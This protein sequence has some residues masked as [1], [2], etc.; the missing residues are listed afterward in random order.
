MTHRFDPTQRPNGRHFRW[1]WALALGCLISSGCQPAMTTSPSARA[2]ATADSG[3]AGTVADWPLTFKHHQFGVVCFD[4]QACE[5]D[6][7]GFSFGSPE[8]SQ[9]KANL[10]ADDYARATTA[11]YGPVARTAAPARVS[12]R[13][14]DGTALQAE[15]DIAELFKDGLVRHR[16]PRA[17]IPDGVS[18]GA[19]HV[20]LEIDDRTIS[21]LTRT[22]IPTREPQIPGNRF[23]SFRDDLIEVS[24]RSY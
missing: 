9:T 13:S 4:T 18:I 10:S 21:V 3:P 17:D 16:V 1:G 8:P 7:N 23:S 24:S 11:S 14:K 6:Y 5:V 12:W 2:D 15:I 22:M 19:T 20:L